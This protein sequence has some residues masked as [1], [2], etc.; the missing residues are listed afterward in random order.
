MKKAVYTS[1]YALTLP[2]PIAVHDSHVCTNPED[3]DCV[4]GFELGVFWWFNY[5]GQL[6][7][8]E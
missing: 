6:L 4:H 1:A 8:T 7:H 5:P 3:K 2:V